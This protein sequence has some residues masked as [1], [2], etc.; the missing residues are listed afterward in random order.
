MVRLTKERNVAKREAAEAVKDRRRLVQQHQRQQQRERSV[1]AGVVTM[2]LSGG[3]QMMVHSR[4]AQRRAWRYQR[5]ALDDMNKPAQQRR[6]R[7]RASVDDVLNS[8]PPLP[9]SR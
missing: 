6:K 4:W 2:N 5:K 3:G 8:L 1:A 7:R 9:T